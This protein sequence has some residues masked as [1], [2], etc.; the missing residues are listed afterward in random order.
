LLI[1]LKKKVI[2]GAQCI[3]HCILRQMVALAL[4]EL[5]A[6]IVDILTAIQLGK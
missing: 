2:L 4:S 3:L 1:G 5:L 6:H